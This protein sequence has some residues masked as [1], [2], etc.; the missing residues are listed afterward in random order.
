MPCV[1]GCQQAV[2]DY[3]PVTMIN[4]GETIP[5]ERNRSSPREICGG[6]GEKA[7]PREDYAVQNWGIRLGGAEGLGY[8]KPRKFASSMKVEDE[9]LN[10]YLGNVV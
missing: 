7:G 8:R 10:K 5:V 9:F 1:C 4:G 3:W 2:S 6:L